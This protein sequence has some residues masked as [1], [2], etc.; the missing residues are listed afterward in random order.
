MKRIAA[1]LLAL[2]LLTA[3]CPAAFAEEPERI[4]ISSTADFRRFAEAC[5]E[6]SY[7]AGRVFE[8]TAD[9]DLSN[10]D[11]APV[12]YFAGIF[13][14]NGHLIA[15]L[16]VTGEGSRLGLF[17]R[18]AE[19]AELHGL[20][21][22]GSVTPGGTACFIGGLVGENA[23][24]LDACS[25][26]GTVGGIENVGG[27]AG[28]NTGT[29]RISGCSFSGALT[30]EHQAGGV[31]G[32]NEGLITNC[33]NSGS[34]NTVAITPAGEMRFDLSAIHE[35]DFL[36]LA[37]IGGIA[38]DNTGELS[39]C[40]NNGS[41]GYK[42]NAYN[43]GGIAGKSTGFVN[44]CLN[45]GDVTGRRDIGG[46]VGQLIPYAVWDFSDGKLDALAGQLNAMQSLLWA[47]SS[48]AQNLSDMVAGELAAMNGYTYDAI[49]AAEDILWQ[50]GANDQ[51]IIDSFYVDP[52]T[53]ETFFGG[54]DIGFPDASALT[55]ALTNMYAESTVLA[56]LA[57]Q[58]VTI[59]AEDLKQVTNQMSAIFNTLS[60]MVASVGNVTG[61]TFDLSLAEC[62]KHDTGAV[63][64]CRNTGTVAAENHAGGVVGTSAFEVDFDMEDR[65]NASDFLL[66]NARRYLFAAV[67]GCDSYG[68][69]T[70]KEEGAGCVVGV[71][72]VGA[73]VDCVGLGEARSAGGDCVGGIAG[74]A[75]GSISGC[76]ARVALSGEKYVGGI[77]GLGTDILE[78]RSWA[79]IDSAREYRGAVAGWAEGNIAGNLYVPDAPAGIDGVSLIDQTRAV[80][81]EELLALKD[82]PG[83]FENLTV[84][85]FFPDRTRLQM[86]V[87][88]GGSIETLP[89]VPNRGDSFWKWDDFDRQ[90][91][92]H[93]QRVDGK[94][95]APDS[96]LSTGEDVPR[97]LAEGMFYEGQKLS[98]ITYSAPLPPEEVLDAATL[99]VNDYEGT[100][101]MRM[102]A[103]ED[104]TLYMAH[105]DGT[106]EK[107]GYRRDGSYIVFTVENGSSVVYAR[108]SGVKESM[109]PILAGGGLGAAAVIV[110][111]ALLARRGKKKAALAAVPAAGGDTPDG[112]GNEASDTEN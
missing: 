55:G 81:S 77:A 109:V 75:G 95:Y 33:V 82:V 60:G 29:G 110:L 24:V 87:P 64:G 31:A 89:E 76:W 6:E 19:G 83:D 51:R 111:I 44:D 104:G 37:N 100:L 96:S 48:D 49:V 54:A 65:L 32:V 46:I 4:R 20:K 84:S 72:D 85:F 42:Y 3:L 112:T 86:E 15:G 71:M 99:Y 9:L 106:L 14:G 36:N 73:V 45:R 68:T 62:Y 102:H 91:I 61:E 11:F 103:P 8:L 67:R 63:A 59:V 57:G 94:Y 79:H 12:P 18:V 56:G 35:D 16:S 21:V 41:V 74:S 93:S 2:L 10:T 5:C 23:G 25:F 70:V 38:G 13:H 22:R 50:M 69:V 34:V 47:V 107:L 27:I 30:A 53:G 108:Q 43:V 101:T 66:S 17:R 58:S 88:F 78:S 40:T 97:F 39:A 98:A 105:S 90:H 28:R 1:A 26:E 80:S 92:Y 7:S 52:E